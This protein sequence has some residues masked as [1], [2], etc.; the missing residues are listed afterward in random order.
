[1]KEPR[2]LLDVILN[3][4]YATQTSKDAACKLYN[5]CRRQVG[6]RK[7]AL[8]RLAQ[9]EAALAAKESER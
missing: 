3:D 5:M 1:M 6:R 7:R 4:P 9:L 2:A 8:D